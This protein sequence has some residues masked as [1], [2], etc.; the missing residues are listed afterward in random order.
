MITRTRPPGKDDS[1]TVTAAA[2]DAHLCRRATMRKR[3]RTSHY[4]NPLLGLVIVAA[5]GLGGTAFAQ[6]ATTK[7]NIA[8]AEQA[9][10]EGK[11]QRTI[12]LTETVLASDPENH[13]AL[14]LRGS[15]RVELGILQRDPDPVR[16]GVADARRA[17]GLAGAANP[18]YYMPYLYGMTH[19]SALESE[20]EH[21]K[22]AVKI[23]DQVL[24]SAEIDPAQESRILYQRGLAKNSLGKTEEAVADFEQAIELDPN[25]LA[26]YTAAANALAAANR[27]PQAK[28]M[29]GRAVQ[30]FPE[31]PLVYNN[32]G[33]FL[34]HT[35]EIEAAIADYTRALEINPNYFYS[36]TNRGVALLQQ[37]KAAAAEA[38][39]TTS[40]QLNP[41]QPMVYGLRG[42]AHLAQGN[43]EAALADH[44][45]AVE[46]APKSPTAITDLAFA[47]YFAGNFQQAAESFQKAV[48]LNP[49][50]RTLLP[51]R[52]AAM[53]ELGKKSSIT[54]QFQDSFSK[55]A[56]NR[57][58]VDNLLS[59]QYH[60]INAEQL[61][62]GVIDE[63]PLKT[64]QSTEAYYF[65]GRGQL[66][67]GNTEAAKQ[68]FQKAIDTGA[69]HLSAYL[70]AKF[71]LQ[72]L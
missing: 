11:Y 45:K 39:F 41:N 18:Y 26:A 60:K 31:N 71:A 25:L 69:K 27:A 10:Q 5:T 61:M 29:Y 51:W 44:Q 72:K 55:P 22:I 56:A 12:N 57:D 36:A 7:Q 20:P 50:Y 64:A 37:G 32:R 35:G 23:A 6:D 19:L 8:Q 38:D 67:A 48:G 68:S 21:A 24:A 70:G 49:N 14:Y 4:T 15:A 62:H 2:S 16:K 28:A 43:F 47:Q 63:E 33:D 34:R 52:V 58:W 66:Q 54:A 42:K 65:I 46:M 40:L 9:Y 13:V 3:M 17:I 1:L 59:Y 53:Q 30:H